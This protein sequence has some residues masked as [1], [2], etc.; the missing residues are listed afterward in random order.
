MDKKIKK[1][2]DAL[3]KEEKEIKKEDLADKVLEQEK[4]KEE[5]KDKKEEAAHPEAHHETIPD[6]DVE[7]RSAD[8]KDE[9]AGNYRQSTNLL[10]HDH[11]V[12]IKVLPS[13]NRMGYYQAE[14]WHITDLA[15]LQS[16]LV[17][18]KT[19]P[20]KQWENALITSVNKVEFFYEAIW[21][22]GKHPLTPDTQIDKEEP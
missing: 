16:M 8:L 4:K 19:D 11:P 3:K 9:T 21:N 18:A 17:E 10:I 6:K 13:E 15:H 7:I 5:K 12:W 1:A 22:D 2:K 14:H 20:K